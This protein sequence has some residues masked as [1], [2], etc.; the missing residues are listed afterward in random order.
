[1]KATCRIWLC[2]IERVFS[3]KAS[4]VQLVMEK[5]KAES[6]WWAVKRAK[7]IGL[8]LEKWS[9]LAVYRAG[10]GCVF[11][12]AIVFF[13]FSLLFGVWLCYLLATCES[14]S[15]VIAYYMFVYY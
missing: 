12:L 8:V 10:G 9:N 5:I 4:S 14:N 3:G 1:M 7:I 2:R 11:W 13:F 15:F 6:Y